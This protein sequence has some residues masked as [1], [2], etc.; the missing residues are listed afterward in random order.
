MV[1]Q[2]ISRVC[3][4]IFWAD[5]WEE[6][7]DGYYDTPGE[8]NPGGANIQGKMFMGL[9]ITQLLICADFMIY[10][11]T[12]ATCRLRL[13]SIPSVSRPSESFELSTE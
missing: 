9:A 3:I 10:W 11:V 13:K 5:A 12:I 4:V 2:F 8:I 1:L 6:L 7:A